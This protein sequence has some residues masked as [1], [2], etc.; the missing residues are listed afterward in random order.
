MDLDIDNELREVEKFQQQLAQLEAMRQKIGTEGISREIGLGLEDLCGGPIP[1]LDIRKLTTN[2]SR[3]SQVAV[4][5][6][7]LKKIGLMVFGSLAMLTLL[8]K[9]FNWLFASTKG[10][11]GGG[12]GGSPA[13]MER[14]L[15]K[16]VEE[17]QDRIREL[18]EN[19]DDVILERWLAEDKFRNSPQ[20]V[21]A[22]MRLAMRSKAYT[23]DQISVMYTRAYEWCMV[24]NMVNVEDEVGK[25][26]PAY[27]A[28]L[29]LV[30]NPGSKLDMRL[31]AFMDDVPALDKDIA[32]SYRARNPSQAHQLH[33]ADR[34]FNETKLSRY[35]S[36]PRM[37]DA[38][39]LA[40]MIYGTVNGIE[41]LLDLYEDMMTGKLNTEEKRAMYTKGVERMKQEL[42]GE[43]SK[44]NHV[45]KTRT[46][47]SLIVL[48]QP[49]GTD[50]Q[51][52]KDIV[53][54]YEAM[55]FPVT[56]AHQ[57]PLPYMAAVPSIWFDTWR[58]YI[59]ALDHATL[60]MTP[61]KPINSRNE[62]FQNQ[63]KAF[64]TVYR[65][66]MKNMDQINTAIADSRSREVDGFYKS[67]N[68][69]SKNLERDAEKIKNRVK[70]MQKMGDDIRYH[71]NSATPDGNMLKPMEAFLNSAIYAAKSLV[72][73][74]KHVEIARKAAETWVFDPKI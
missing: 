52:M 62:N 73:F 13:A 47:D 33:M 55:G 48:E 44:Y 61:P 30:T 63:M 27:L 50:E 54:R 31:I 43:S 11:P 14:E 19:P 6:I 12:G 67:I 26:N 9:M 5:A 2:P 72:T 45:S 24:W 4:E 37:D 60:T 16:K 41:R 68:K 23:P 59:E 70:G 35:I 42:F 49:H 18:E 74:C 66:M 40:D 39:N 65:F 38:N 46:R 10:N 32:R 56:S 8:I 53:M 17:V 21:Q 25:M 29:H 15:E 1:G 7:D 64:M 3:A 57:E 22:L 51:T 71:L 69:I 58:M 20:T 34:P 36:S 28:M